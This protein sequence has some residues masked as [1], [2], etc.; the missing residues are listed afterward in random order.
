MLSGSPSK[1]YQENW[2]QNLLDR[3]RSS[4]SNWYS[5]GQPRTI[6]R[7]E[8]SSYPYSRELSDRPNLPSQLQRRPTFHGESLS[9]RPYG[10]SD[11]FSVARQ[12]SPMEQESAMNAD[13][14]FAPTFLFGSRPQKRRSMVLGPIGVGSNL[15]PAGIL[16]NREDAI[17]SPVRSRTIS[18]HDAPQE[19]EI[20]SGSSQE[21]DQE[22]FSDGP[23]RR[24]LVNKEPP[25]KISRLQADS[26]VEDS[27]RASLNFSLNGSVFETTSASPELANGHTSK[28]FWLTVFGFPRDNVQDVMNLFARHGNIVAHKIPAE[29]NW[30]HIRYSSLVHVKQ[31]L[32]RN[33]QTYNG[34]ML[35]V[36][37]CT[38][39]ELA[40]HDGSARMDVNT[41]VISAKTS[42]NNGG[43]ID[44]SFVTNMATR[45]IPSVSS[46]NSTDSPANRSRLST[47]LRAGMRPLNASLISDNLNISL[48]QQPT[49]RK[50]DTLIGK[51]WNFVAQT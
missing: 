9:R 13:K 4:T 28:D 40:E 29:G 11:G 5:S 37:S 41:S 15:S 23:P 12:A 21:S 17:P 30:V 49:A 34:I 35:G 1:N 26:T 24:S 44:S 33:A 6:I 31:A 43:A 20:H 18:S 48:E 51:L 38:D 16:K 10:M 32:S 19:I 14:Q 36:V 7:D 42:S 22:I 46:S 3:D 27:T 2:G 47:S 50:S 8:D 25:A 45:Q 39:K